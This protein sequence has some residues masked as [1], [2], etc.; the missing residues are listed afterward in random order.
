M[1]E[2]SKSEEMVLLAVWRLG[3]KADGVSIRSQ[4]LKDAGKD[5]T[6]GTLY[7]LLRQ[8]DRKGYIQKAKAEPLP[9]KGGR[10]KSY[11]R[12]TPSGIRALKEAIEL[13]KRVWKNI[14]ALSLSES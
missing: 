3:D 7:G 4:I 11:Y 14:N 6:Y 2:V 12:L 13:H 5:Y 10:S 9:K 8:M 1:K